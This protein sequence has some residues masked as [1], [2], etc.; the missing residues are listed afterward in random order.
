MI[1]RSK[2]DL[3]KLLQ[4]DEA[5]TKNEKRANEILQILH[6]YSQ[7]MVLLPSYPSRGPNIPGAPEDIRSV[8]TLL[9]ELRTLLVKDADTADAVQLISKDLEKLMKTLR[10]SE[11]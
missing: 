10:T 2:A 4:A 8:L 3:I 5:F 6:R 1:E 11:Q 7:G 9:E